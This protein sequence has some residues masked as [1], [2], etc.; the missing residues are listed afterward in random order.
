MANRRPPKIN[1]HHL[2][3]ELTKVLKRMILDGD[4]PP[5]ERLLE[6][7]LAEDLGTSRTPVREALLRLEQEG[8]L[9]R[10]PQGGLAVRPL[11]PEEVEEAVGVR[12]LLEAYAARLAAKNLDPRVLARLE[13]NVAQFEKALKE[14]KPDK[15]VEINTNFH[16]TLY[17]AASS[18]LLYRLISDLQDVLHRFRRALL[19]DG[20]AAAAS[21]ADHR[22]L[23]QALKNGDSAGA[24]R[25]C[26]AHVKR[27]GRWM[28]ER[29][30]RGELEL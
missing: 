30:K 16:D 9:H 29:I 11:T 5:G 18:E 13:A 15:L 24:G 28:L 25:I 2:G 23:V 4:F 7:H 19:G 22:K 17:K 1:R 12:A 6:V 3:A 26:S 8:L 10:R 21:L 20:Q 27:G 14:N